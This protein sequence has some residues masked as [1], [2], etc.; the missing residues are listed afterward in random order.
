MPK[1]KKKILPAEKK[2]KQ[3]L[4]QIYYDADNAGSFGGINPLM[5]EVQRLKRQLEI[6]K[7]QI[8]N[9]TEEWLSSQL[10]YS[11]HRQ[12]IYKF[13]RNKMISHGV[14]HIWQSDL[15]DMQPLA[16]ENDGY[17]YLLVIIDT[18]SRFV[19]ME[20]LKNKSGPEVALAMEKV[21]SRSGRRKPVKLCT[22]M[23]KEYLNKH[24]RDVMEKYNIHHYAMASDT[25]AA[26]VE[27]V[28]R[29]LKE[30]MWRYFTFIHPRPRRYIDILQKLVDSYNRRIHRSIGMAP[31]DVRKSDEA[32]LWNL[33]FGK[34]ELNKRPQRFEKGDRVRIGQKKDVFAKGYWGNWSREIFMIK[35]VNLL[36]SY[37]MYYL[38]DKHGETIKGAF[39]A[40]Q[41]QKVSSDETD[42]NIGKEESVSDKEKIYEVEKI[43]GHM[44]KIN[45]V[46][47]RFVKWKGF[48]KSYNQWIPVSSIQSLNK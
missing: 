1:T 15:C 34:M 41:L 27:R 23:G 5:L 9:V 12:Q 43:I 36:H 7:S 26:I 19:W 25:K 10:P 4:S 30:R 47:H 14:D 28:N 40:Q 11:R 42:N 38:E 24:V 6:G 21:L 8:R 33:Q 39:Y 29:T 18:F 2:I 32:R 48:P 17:R 35:D 13:P 45:G 44:R 3:L 16:K 20:A 31:V 37:P 22:D 46:P